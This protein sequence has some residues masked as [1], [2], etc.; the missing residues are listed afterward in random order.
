MPPQTGDTVLVTNGVYATGGRPA[1]GS[2][3]TNRVMVTN[4][5]TLLSA[6]GPELTVIQ[7][8]EAPWNYYR[9]SFRC[10]CLGAGALL[11]GFTLTNGV[12]NEG[13]GVWCGTNATVTGCVL[14][15]NHA[16]L[17]GGGA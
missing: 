3:L 7:G 13:G 12:A 2:T 9:S 10:V 8:A 4:A 11:E 15:S 1:P 5:I 16:W 6:T 17:Y 14:I